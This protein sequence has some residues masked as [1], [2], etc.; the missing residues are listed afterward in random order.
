MSVDLLLPPVS[1]TLLVPVGM[2]GEVVV[3]YRIKKIRTGMVERH[4]FSLDLSSPLHTVCSRGSPPVNPISAST[5]YNIDM[6]SIAGF[7]ERLT[8]FSRSGRKRNDLDRNIFNRFRSKSWF[9]GCFPTTTTTTAI[10]T[11]IT[12]SSS[13]PAH[14]KVLCPVCLHHHRKTG[15]KG[16]SSTARK[17]HLSSC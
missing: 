10:T 12:S 15:A 17:L 16:I 1:F 9:H 4:K 3:Q 5:W 2:L 6:A 11:M 7:Q 8:F 13:R 14:P